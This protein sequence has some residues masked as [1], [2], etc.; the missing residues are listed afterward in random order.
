MPQDAGEAARVG[1]CE[2]PFGCFERQHRTHPLL[3]GPMAGDVDRLERSLLRQ[4]V[5]EEVRA[6]ALFDD[7]LHGKARGRFEDA[8]LL[9][10]EVEL[11]LA[12]RRGSHEHYGEVTMARCHGLLTFAPADAPEDDEPLNMII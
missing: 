7:E 12:P 11:L 9:G 5:F 8:C 2:V 6:A 10:F 3:N 1:Q 4:A